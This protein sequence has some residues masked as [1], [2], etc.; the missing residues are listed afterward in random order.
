MSTT[1]KRRKVIEVAVPLP[2]V[3]PTHFWLELTPE[4]RAYTP[5]E[6]RE[7]R[8]DI[9]GKRKGLSKAERR[10]L[11]FVAM[12]NGLGGPQRSRPYTVGGTL[13]VFTS[14][15]AAQAVAAALRVRLRMHR[16]RTAVVVRQAGDLE[17]YL[18]KGGVP[19]LL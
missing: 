3:R 10:L 17:A 12:Y 9:G 1:R 19:P 16:S 14:K 13:V 18:A 6:V 15:A 4:C 11:A 2:E 5:Q 7:W 8:K